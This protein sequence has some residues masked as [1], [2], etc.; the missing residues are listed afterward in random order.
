MTET[1]TVF[2]P[3]KRSKAEARQ[4]IEDG[5][6]K[7]AEQLGGAAQVEQVWD[8]DT[9][10]FTASAAGQ[11]IPGT[12]VV[13]NEDIRIDVT[14]PWLLAKIAGPISEKLRKDTQLLLDKK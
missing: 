3:N 8:G 9:M 11:T 1:I 10:R 5:F 4:R 7:V 6:D 14:L 13:R 2:V 12:L